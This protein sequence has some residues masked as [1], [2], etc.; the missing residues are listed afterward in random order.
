MLSIDSLAAPPVP[1][2]APDAFAEAGRVSQQSAGG[3]L[4]AEAALVRAAA[5]DVISY[6]AAISACDKGAQPEQALQLLRGM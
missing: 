1:S 6:S 3:Q 4:Q 2:A 5:A